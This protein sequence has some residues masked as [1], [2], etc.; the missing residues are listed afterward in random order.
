MIEK[1][2]PYPVKIKFVFPR[3]VMSDYEDFLVCITDLKDHDRK[4][5]NDSRS[6]D[7]TIERVHIRVP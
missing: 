5:V 2:Y 4:C 3:N 1:S 7:T 6:P